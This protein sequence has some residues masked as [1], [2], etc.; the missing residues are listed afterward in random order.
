MF[1]RVAIVGPGLIGGSIGMCLRQR[2]LAGRVVGI[3]RRERSLQ[4]AMA[5]GAIDESTLDLR[6]GV[7]GA[8]L[9][10]L[11]TPVSAFADLTS[12]A[13]PALKSGA[14]L[15]DVASTKGGV[16]RA[17]SAALSQRPDIVY[18]PTHPMAGS[19]QR[20][21]LAAQADLF[22][23]AV[24]IITPLS[25]AEHEAEAQVVSMWDALGAR[26]VIMTPEEHDHVVARISHVPHLVAAALIDLVTED[27]TQLCGG[28]LRDTTRIASGDPDLWMDICAANRDEI[29]RALTEY[30]ERL[31]R[32]AEW[33]NSG[34]LEQL[35]K[36][37]A[38]AKDKRDRTIG[39]EQ[40]PSHWQ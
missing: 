29:R 36:M 22:E 12:A 8:D 16:V 17:I 21:A 31:Q 35:R 14:I 20:G 25:S 32:A 1:E 34:D 26:T 7:A 37:L 4:N 18:V 23:G 33:L 11:A 6:E 3:G 40:K 15:T 10:V 13:A 2:E 38:H 9:V 19:E 28:G 27:Q 30:I 5:V 24:C 39:H